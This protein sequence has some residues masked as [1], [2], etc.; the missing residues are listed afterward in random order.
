[1]KK[2][3]CTIIFIVLLFSF[4]SAEEGMWPLDQ[5][6]N[7]DWKAIKAMGLEL[8]PTE[9]YN[10]DAADISDAVVQL[11][12]GTGTFVSA[13]GLIL[14]NHHVAYGAIQ[15]QSSAELDF[16]RNGFLAENYLAELPAKGYRA[17]I[18]IFQADANSGAVAF[19]R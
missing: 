17:R 2:L 4:V 18:C 12:G 16:I 9:I 10:P 3:I 7:L 1:M 19:C 11:G 8:S 6:A 15:R 5:L 13:K 14:T